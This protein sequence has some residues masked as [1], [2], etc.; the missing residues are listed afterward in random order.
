MAPIPMKIPYDKNLMM[1]DDASGKKSVTNLSKGFYYLMY[2]AKR[3][4]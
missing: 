1:Q 2:F 4:T 3:V